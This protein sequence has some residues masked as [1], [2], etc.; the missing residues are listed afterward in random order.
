MALPSGPPA[1]QIP[2]FLQRL[3]SNSG[4]TVAEI[5]RQQRGEMPRDQM[6]DPVGEEAP[7][8]GIN[9]QAQKIT[10]SVQRLDS[11][12]PDSPNTAL[13]R[14]LNILPPTTWEKSVAAGGVGTGK[15]LHESHDPLLRTFTAPALLG[16]SAASEV[17]FSANITPNGVTS[18]GPLIS[19]SNAGFPGEQT[20]PDLQPMMESFESEL[21]HSKTVACDS[22][23]PGVCTARLASKIDTDRLV[24]P[25][26]LLQTATAS[27]ASSVTTQVSAIPSVYG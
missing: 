11:K 2:P 23:I 8:G 17:P 7:S 13:K 24:T 12:E 19:T 26:A 3:M 10:P 4:A 9:G 27:H 20:G 25:Q 22:N 6:P 5:E 16:I 1:D 14:S 15:L 18:S 21:K